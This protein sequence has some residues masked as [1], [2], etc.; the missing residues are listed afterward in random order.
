M[1]GHY[2]NGNSN[3]DIRTDSMNVNSAIQRYTLA[4]TGEVYDGHVVEAGGRLYTTSGNTIEH[5]SQLLNELPSMMASNMNTTSRTAASDVNPV[6]STWNR[7]D[8]SKYDRTYYLPINFTGPT[9][10]GK[11]GEAVQTGTPLHRHRNRQTM[12]EHSMDKTG[13]D[14]SVAVTTTK[15]SN[16]RSRVGS[17]RVNSTRENPRGRR[18]SQNMNNTGT[19]QTQQRTQRRTQTR[20]RTSMGGRTGGSY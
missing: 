16:V 1:P 13:T 10:Y 4:L 19:A 8:G 15:P 3:G 5:N 17:R 14:A 11:P 6:I 12:T 2:N 18:T 7:G 9:A 20:T